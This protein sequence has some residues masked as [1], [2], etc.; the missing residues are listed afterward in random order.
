MVAVM[1][2]ELDTPFGLRLINALIAAQAE[3]GDYRGRQAAAIAVVPATLNVW[4][5]DYVDLRVDDAED[6]M[7]ELTRLYDKRWKGNC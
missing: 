5:S 4:E 6:P 7:T 3:G 2:T 1:D